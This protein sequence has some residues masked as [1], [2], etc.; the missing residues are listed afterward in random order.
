MQ[1]RAN[2]NYT[3]KVERID[4]VFD[5]EWI[6]STFILSDQE[7]VQGDEYK[8]FVRKNRYYSSA[9]YKFTGTSPGM[10]IA[11]NPK[12]QFTRYSDI[13]S[14]GRISK[15]LGRGDITVNTTVPGK[16]GLGLG[17]YYSEAI[18]DNEQRIFLRFGVPKYQFITAWLAKS[19]DIDRAV[20]QSRGIITDTIRDVA[21]TATSLITGLF[22]LAA[23]PLLSIALG[24][25]RLLNDDTRLYT[26]KETMYIYWATVDTLLNK[27][28]ARRTM[29]PYVLEDLSFYLEKP[30]NNPQN[31]TS[32]F[33]SSLNEVMPDIIDPETGKISVFAIAL[34][35]QAAYNKM[36]HEDFERNKT[37][38]LSTDFEGFRET[39]E[40][41]HQTYFTNKFGTP[42]LFVKYIFETAYN[43]LVSPQNDLSSEIKSPSGSS[44]ATDS[45]IEYDPI[46]R[47]PETGQPID[48]T[49]DPN[50]PND[51]I[52]AKIDANVKK[53]KSS[54]EKYGEYL[55][56]ELTEGA[57]F[58]VFNVDFT[59]S[60]GESFSNN[61]TNHPLENMFNAASGKTRI[62]NELASPL[63]AIPGV[64]DII[65]IMGDVAAT[66][67]STATFG[68]ANPLIGL[69]YGVNVSLPKIWESS[70]ANLPRANYKIKLISPYGNAYSQLFNIYLPL[71]MLL[72]AS[73]PRSTGNST[74]IGP[75]LC[76]LFDRGRI[77]ISLGMVEN[78]TITR[79]TSNLAFTKAGHAN[80]IDVEISIANL[81][82][83]IALDI[84]SNGVL[85]R[86]FD[87]IPSLADSPLENYLNAITAVDVYQQIYKIPKFRLKLAEKY[88]IAKSILT[89][90]AGW[91]AFSSD[92][93]PNV[94]GSS[95]LGDNNQALMDLMTR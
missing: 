41:S 94:L 31:P 80:A 70:S 32:Q 18:D 26:M 71:A 30:I 86:F 6:K 75:F 15:N 38:P 91:A 49:I 57:S 81:D 89:D 33:I 29:V 55:L 93:I 64:S 21:V 60:V 46:Y 51:N 58:A 13:R 52:Y 95:I 34:R 84:T 47:D 82:E 17:A 14:D 74:H 12:P 39:G 19:F 78:I 7:I 28:V 5:N 79:G 69:L 23:A 10:N 87:D 72:A 37:K 76:Q 44:S 27:M 42:H 24:A 85:M 36:L 65:G 43:L 25:F 48:L 53:R 88:M 40:V 66:F 59:G 4:D 9:D 2:T 63:K 45:L 61:V 90:E 22:R 77:N 50:N 83:V 73:L 92:K 62:F 1:I 3:K 67:V 54:L 11:V 68:L 56:A 8:K 20:F 35:A 16:Y